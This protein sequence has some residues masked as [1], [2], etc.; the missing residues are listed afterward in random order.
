M[1]QPERIMG[2][3][4][5][6]MGTYL[7]LLC[8]L[9]LLA[10]GFAYKPPVVSA[11]GL[12]PAE[13]AQYILPDGTLPILCVTGAHEGGGAKSRHDAASSRCEVCRLTQSILPEGPST[14]FVAVAAMIENEFPPD[15]W[16]ASHSS[17]ASPNTGPRAPPH[18][19]LG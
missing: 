2:K 7:R 18:R 3:T 9:A 5:R 11:A 10:F 15:D 8:A 19:T 17:P 16:P 1:L 13:L 12:T 4:L 14:G 6:S